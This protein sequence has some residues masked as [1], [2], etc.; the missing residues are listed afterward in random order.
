MF[1]YIEYINNFPYN[2]L[3]ALGIGSIGIFLA[4]IFYFKA[5]KNKKPVYAIRSFNI[6]K[7]FVSGIEKL[8]ILFSGQ[9]IQNLTASKI[10][11]FN[12]GKETINGA[13]IS[14]A[15]P[16]RI[17]VGNNIKILSF[18]VLES[19]PAN[20][21]LLTLEED[22]SSVLVNFDY[23]DFEEGVLFKI[24]HTGK[25]SSD[26]KFVGSMKGAKSLKKINPL[27]VEE[28][29]LQ[30]INPAFGKMVPYFTTKI[31]GSFFIF[32]G[33]SLILF[34]IFAPAKNIT[35]KVMGLFFA[36]LISPMLPI[37]FSI[38]RNTLPLGFEK[39][40]SDSDI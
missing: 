33:L 3:I 7:D 19:K 39:F 38:L 36:L 23:I 26:L 14:S 22:G 31:L 1:D 12:K 24:L 11:F 2:N 10:I 28:S 8:E 21:F 13:D 18:S 9:K 27:A 25:S 34:I 37:G 40:H 30:K 6:I 17:E 32:F 16:L 4:I 35:S 5:L 29:K 15:D 20:N